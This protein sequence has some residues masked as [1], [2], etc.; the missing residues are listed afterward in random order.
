MVR[1]ADN[2]CE[3]LSDNG[4]T[5]YVSVSSTPDSYGDMGAREYYRFGSPNQ[6]TFRLTLM[7][8]ELLTGATYRV[9]YCNKF[10]G[11]IWLCP[12]A[13]Y[14]FGHYPKRLDVRVWPSHC[15]SI[16]EHLAHIE[17]EKE[18][19]DKYRKE[20]EKLYEDEEYDLE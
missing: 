5:L 20:Q 14:V 2:L 1:G 9:E 6:N 17:K 15:F 8:S 7:E 12:V 4:R 19:I 18:E 10:R 16:G 3:S 13:L 11:I